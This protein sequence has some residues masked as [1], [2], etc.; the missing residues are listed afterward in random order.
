MKS[1]ISVFLIILFGCSILKYNR[2]DF[3]GN[4]YIFRGGQLG[5]YTIEF[6]D[7]GVCYSERGG[8]FSGKGIWELTDDYKFIIIKVSLE[9]PTPE[10]F[11]KKNNIGIMKKGIEIKLKIKSKN[12]LIGEDGMVFE[13]V[14]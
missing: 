1:I 6:K 14:E 9:T 12:K 5:D 4:Q 11:F 7:D 10:L 13:I 3:A 2:V 8:L